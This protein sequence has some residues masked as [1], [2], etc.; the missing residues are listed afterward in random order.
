MRKNVCPV[1]VALLL[2]FSGI[3]SFPYPAAAQRP[4]RV[5]YLSGNGDQQLFCNIQLSDGTLLFGGTADDLSWVPGNVSRTPISRIASNGSRIQDKGVSEGRVAFLMHVAEDLS[6]ILNI[7]HFPGGQVDEVRFIKTTNIPGQPTGDIYVSGKFGRTSGGSENGGF[8][9]AKLDNNFVNGLPTGLTNVYTVYTHN[10]NDEH[11]G[12]QPWDVRENGQVVTLKYGAYKDNWGEIY[13]AEADP[14][15]PASGDELE[16]GERRILMP[17]FR[18]HQ[19]EDSLGNTQN[20]YGTADEIPNGWTPVTSFMILKTQRTNAS[21]LQRSFSKADYDLWQLDENGY[22]RKGKYPLDA[23]WNNYW[24]VPETNG[25]ENNMWGGDARGYIGYKLA[26]TGGTEGS[27]YTPRVGAITVDRRNGHIY[28][29]LNWQSRL[30][31]SNFPDFE[32]AFIALDEDGYYKWWCRLYKEY[33]DNSTSPPQLISGTVTAGGSKTTFTSTALAGVSID[34]GSH[35]SGSNGYVGRKREIRF[36]TGNN[37]RN[38]PFQIESFNSTT[39]TL[40]LVETLAQNIQPGDQFEIQA[41]VMN[42]TNTSTPDQYIDAIAVDYTT[43]LDAQG[44]KGIVYVA[45]R[46]HG[47]NVVNFWRGNEITANPSVFSFHNGFTGNNGNE[48]LSWIGR[49]RDDETKATLLNATYNAEFEETSDYGQNGSF[50]STYS[51]PNLDRWPSHNSGWPNLK[52]TRL[53]PTMHIDDQGRPVIISEDG[54]ATVTTR[55]AYQRN[56]RPVIR[57]SVTAA[58]DNQSFIS[59]GL[60]GSGLIQSAALKIKFTSNGPL[61]NVERNIITYDDA[62][63]EV[64]VS[65]ALPSNPSPGDQ[66]SIDEGQGN[67][68]SYVRVY[69]RDLSTLEYSS[70]LSP[71]RDP[72][73]ATDDG[74]HTRLHGGLSPPG[75]CAGL[76]I[77]SLR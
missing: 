34:L 18:F 69:S 77:S 9:I 75:W 65:S 58:V 46:S 10:K 8:Y 60:I 36:L 19:I 37:V 76:R 64:T 27:P 50:G 1:A 15:G 73:G 43:P 59:D 44:Y 67:W 45:A 12:V 23:F 54:R 61:K 22:W 31:G 55:N 5:F 13:V 38:E 42:K 68:N 71:Q 62:T 14:A 28:M 51:D 63:G 16:P 26:G 56:I 6:S 3:L 7:V 33:S 2:A 21:G 72:T 32:P 30:P 40:T 49:L 11:A 24:K 74:N 57:D 35:G 52:T 25:A 66:F 4:D 20:F 47:N 29:G 41:A 17:G 70:L 53:R 48:H 39:G